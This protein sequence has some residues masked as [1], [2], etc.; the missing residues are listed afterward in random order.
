MPAPK[1]FNALRSDAQ[2]N[3]RA[4]LD[5]AASVLC[6]QGLDASLDEVSRRAGVGNA[7]LYRHFPTREKLFEAVYLAQYDAWRDT[8]E[9]ILTIED[10]WAALVEY[11]HESA[12]MFAA[13]HGLA[14]LLLRGMP[15]SAELDE[16]RDSCVA[17]LSVLL[18]RARDQGSVRADLVLTDLM[19]LLNALQH[20]VS[21]SEPDYPDAWRRYLALSLGGLRPHG[22]QGGLPATTLDPDA[23]HTL[24]CPRPPTHTPRHARDNPEPGPCSEG[25]SR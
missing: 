10:G 25:R 15:Q 1:P 12:R 5:A 3:R 8:R 19:W 2:R 20:V 9:R 17:T 14:D 23:F 24:L 16:L 13:D 21:V 22:S 18:E 11:F 7:T 4:L 6:E